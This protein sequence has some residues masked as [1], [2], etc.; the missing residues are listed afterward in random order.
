MITIEPG[1]GEPITVKKLPIV[2]ARRKSVIVENG[3]AE[4]L[5]PPGFVAT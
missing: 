4:V 3:M 5:E 2:E 1:T